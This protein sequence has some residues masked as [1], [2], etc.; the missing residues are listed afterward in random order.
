MNLRK[1][2]I[3]AAHPATVRRARLT[4]LIVG[5]LLV[6]INHGSAIIAGQVTRERIFQILLTYAVP[7][8]V[9]TT[10]SIMTR[11]EMQSA[12]VSIIRS[13]EARFESASRKG[14]AEEVPI[15]LADSAF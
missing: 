6:A 15:S 9:S 10:S 1:W 11:N 13:S 14:I 8:L 12:P 5:T 4:S 3:L 2:L 7:Y